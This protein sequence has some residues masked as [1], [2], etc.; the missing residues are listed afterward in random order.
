MPSLN[1]PLLY[2]GTSSTTS[3]LGFE[4]FHLVPDSKRMLE[5]GQQPKDNAS[6]SRREETANKEA[7]KEVKNSCRYSTLI[8][9]K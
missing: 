2:F 8:I 7:E 3:F 9:L 1:F 5:K 6:L 4:H